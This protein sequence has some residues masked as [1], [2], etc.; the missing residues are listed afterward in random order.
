[1]KAEQLAFGRALYKYD[2]HLLVPY[3]KMFRIY[4]RISLAASPYRFL[5]FVRSTT[6]PGGLG[7]AAL[8]CWFLVLEDLGNAVGVGR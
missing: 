4:K 7:S 8:V 6:A 5:R 3:H 1:M 2:V